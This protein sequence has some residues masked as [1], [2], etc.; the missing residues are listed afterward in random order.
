MSVDDD[1]TGAVAHPRL[2][3]ADADLTDREEVS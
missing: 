2:I 3:G 1:T